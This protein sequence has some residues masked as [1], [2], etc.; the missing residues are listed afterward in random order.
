MGGGGGVRAIVTHPGPT[1]DGGVKIEYRQP[2]TSAGKQE[3][4]GPLRAL[5]GTINKPCYC[6]Q[7]FI[8]L[9]CLFCVVLG[10]CMFF[11]QI[12]FYDL[13]YHVLITHS[14]VVVQ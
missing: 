14:R 7:V 10:V 4:V 9:V 8:L 6:V 11:L 13:K 12:Y 1:T 5:G 2:V 3:K